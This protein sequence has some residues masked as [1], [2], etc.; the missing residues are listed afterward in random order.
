[1]SC[2]HLLPG[3]N[4][5]KKDHIYN[6]ITIMHIVGILNLCMTKIRKHFNSDTDISSKQT[7]QVHGRS[8]LPSYIHHPATFITNNEFWHTD[9][10]QY[11]DRPVGGR[12]LTWYPE[13]PMIRITTNVQGV[14]S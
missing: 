5:P 2:T 7:E 9:Y 13:T 3:S 6:I 4:R 14:I 8:Q 12:P 10:Y 1:M 11:D